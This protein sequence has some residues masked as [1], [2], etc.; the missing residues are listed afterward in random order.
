MELIIALAISAVLVAA[1]YRTF[2]T[3]HH[4]FAVQDDVLDMQQNTRVALNEMIREIRMAGFGNI[5]PILPV[6]I[7][8]RT[9]PYAINPDVPSKGALT[10]LAAIGGTTTLTGINPPP[11]ENQI[12]VSGAALF[13]TIKRK[14]ISIA[15][16]ESYVIIN[17][18]TNTLTLDRKVVTSFKTDGNTPVHAIRAIT[19]LVP[20]GT[21]VLRRNENWGGGAQP[22]AEDIENVTFQYFDGNGNPTLSPLAFRTIRVTVTARTKKADLRFKAGAGDGYRR[23]QV[24]SNILLRNMGL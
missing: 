10:I 18:S 14:Y 23:R 5:G 21:T 17:I 13:D 7:S 19:Y 2:L 4:G 15:G 9:Y 20:S 11:N 22:L 1:L 8:G 3:Q 16:I 24:S 6:T 12:M